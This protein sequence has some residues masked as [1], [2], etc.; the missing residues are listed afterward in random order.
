MILKIVA[1][2]CSATIMLNSKNQKEIIVIEKREIN[3]DI[4]E[5]ILGEEILGGG[6]VSLDKLKEVAVWNEYQKAIL[7]KFRRVGGVFQ[8]TQKYVVKCDQ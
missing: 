3:T 4:P 8:I 6:K 1:K 2:K 5:E 7:L